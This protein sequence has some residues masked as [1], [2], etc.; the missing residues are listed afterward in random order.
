MY[1]YANLVAVGTEDTLM[2]Y[3]AAKN[4]NNFSDPSLWLKAT[5]YPWLFLGENK[6]SVLLLLTSY[7]CLAF[8]FCSYWKVNNVR[9][10]FAE[11]LQHYFTLHD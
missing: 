8:C 2:G 7:H 9:L 4:R 11:L 10:L 1:Y 5:P 6:R 3:E